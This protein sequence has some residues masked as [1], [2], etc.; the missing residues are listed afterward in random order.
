[1][2]QKIIA[3]LFASAILVLPSLSIAE[4]LPVGK[5]EIQTKITALLAEVSGLQRQLD[6]VKAD[7]ESGRVLRIWHLLESLNKGTRSD[8][9]ATLQTLLAKDVQIYPE[10]Y[11][12]G[13]YGKL[14]SAAVERFKNKHDKPRVSVESVAVPHIFGLSATSTKTT[15]TVVWGTDVP[16]S[17][18]IWWGSPGPLD[19]ERMTPVSTA[20]LSE[21]HQAYFSGGIFAS[22]TYA[23]VI[24]VSNKDGNT[25]TT[26]EQIYVTP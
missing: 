14:T 1:M 17:A 26:T 4:T 5:A 20:A 3:P 9:V 13:Y 10:G 25:S 22:T 8:N 23:F 24:A 21:S 7:D 11:V 12:T 6:A 18:K 2:N 15:M 16:T 19:T